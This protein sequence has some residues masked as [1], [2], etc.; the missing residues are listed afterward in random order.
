MNSLP[1]SSETPAVPLTGLRLWLRQGENLLLCS[2]LVALMVLPLL[3]AF[4]RKAFASGIPGATTLVQH[5]T[6]LIAMLGGALAARDSR[7]LAMSA[8]PTIL[9]PKWKIFAAHF[10]GTMATTITLFLTVAGIEFVKTERESGNFL[11]GQIPIWWVQIVTPIGFALVTWRLLWNASPKWWGRAVVFVASGLLVWLATHPPTD[12][13]KL[14]WP[15]IATLLVATVLGSPIFVTLGGAAMILF[16][17]EDLP[18][19]SIPLDH[20]RLVT[21]ATLPTIPLFTLAGYLLAEGGASKRLVGVFQA[22][23]GSFR[24]G[25]AIVTALVC[26]FFT[27][28]TG[29]SGVTILAMGGLLMPVMLAARY[30]ERNA[31]GLLTGSGALGLLF[32]PSLPLILYA[33]IAGSKAQAAGVTIEKMFLAGLLPGLLLVALTAWWGVSRG[34]KDASDRPKFCGATARAAMWEAKWELAVPFVA[35]G[36]LFGGIATPVEAAAVTALYVFIATVFIHRDLNLTTDIPRVLTECGLLVGGVLMILGVALGLTNYLVDAQIPAKA[37]EWV[38]GTI[39]SKWVFLL[40]LNVLLL[41]VGCFMDTFSA[42]VVVVPLL[43]PLGSAYG[44]DPL[45]LGI[46]FLANMELGLLA[47]TVGI[48]IFLASYRF[49]KPVM[50]V[51]RAVLP[52]QGV[53]LIGVLLITYFPPLTTWLPGLLGR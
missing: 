50:E 1:V 25:P 34:P 20:Y 2:I 14:V 16:W 42:I 46:I 53:L 12:P 49:K 32:P 47:P 26:T 48:N 4:L 35:L 13:A 21:N 28:F 27:S 15:A 6:L 3:E 29:A 11:V 44:I 10:S 24:G 23:F 8:L 36:A 39:H 5:C 22:L 37:V 38:T 51:S 7:L 43:V 9:S 30:S 33:I 45:H 17:G 31:L 52:M 41:L 18:I 40:V 19:A